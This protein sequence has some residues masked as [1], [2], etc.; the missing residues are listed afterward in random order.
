[1][2]LG[3]YLLAEL[4][5]VWV[6]T[7]LVRQFYGDL[8]NRSL[9]TSGPYRRMRHPRYTFLLLG[10]AGITLVFAS[11]L[12]GLLTLGW[13]VLVLRRIPKEEAHLGTI[14]GDDYDTYIRRS[15]R[16]VPGIY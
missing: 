3:L 6:D 8:A 5:L 16:L 14:F 15:A 9:V 13:L 2:G 1:V 7:F 10:K 11:L 4:G 12:G